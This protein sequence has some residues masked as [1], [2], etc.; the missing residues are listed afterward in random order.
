M[1]KQHGFTV[2]TSMLQELFAGLKRYTS[3]YSK[4]CTQIRQQLYSDSKDTILV[5]A[6]KVAYSV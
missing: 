4:S 1:L 5:V 2:K 6:T 3:A